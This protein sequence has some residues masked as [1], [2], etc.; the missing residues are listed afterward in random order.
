MNIVNKILYLGIDK[1]A[2]KEEV[3][4]IWL[5]NLLVLVPLP[6]FIFATAFSIMYNYPRV[7]FTNAI[8]ALVLVC[9]LL[10]NYSKKYT[11]AKFV[12]I[13]AFATVVLVYYK[14]MDNEASMFYYFFPLIL[15]M[16]LFYDVKQEKAVMILTATILVGIISV[17]LFLPAAYFQPWPLS[18]N[19]H[20]L[21]GTTNAI[22]C[23][24][25]IVI[26]TYNIF[27]QNFEK[28]QELIAAKVQAEAAA[29]A[30]S[31]FLRNMSHELRTPL[32]GIIGS[33]NILHSDIHTNTKEHVQVM[34]NLAMHMTNLVNDILDFDKIGAGKL[35]LHHADFSL[36][37]E[38]E[39]L[40]SL[41]H[42]EC[43]SKGIKYKTEIDPKLNDVI[44]LSDDLRLQQI[45]RN[46]IS[47]AIK[48]TAKGSVTLKI[49]EETKD[50]N[51]V[52]ITFNVIDEGIGIE[53]EKIDSVFESFNQGDSATTRKYGGSGLGLSISA[54]LLK[55]FGSKFLVRSKLGVGSNFSFTIKFPLS[56][57]TSFQEKLNTPKTTIGNLL[58]N[59]KVL[60]AEDNIINMKIAKL[61]LQKWGV[62]VEEANNGKVA[63]EKCKIQDFDLILLD[64][65][66]PE[67]DGKTA[68]KQINT[69]HKNIPAIAFTA[70]MYE[71][72]DQDLKTHGF[73]T[74]VTKPFK[75]EVLYNTMV[76]SLGLKQAI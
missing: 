30:K 21:I 6:L 55:M 68:V 49:N 39:K 23:T 8:F 31:V 12:F 32:N 13:T 73:D 66:M 28:E 9:I 76:A 67:M 48:F 1:N 52:T 51:F 5:V 18:N 40:H 14:L 70:A 58:R 2:T 42:F 20:K 65:E 24:L 41:Y 19:L 34:K 33:A 46:L 10:L 37:N 3:L 4:K 47:N 61:I 62:Q 75:P 63:F 71:D 15:C 56:K 64:L 11:L 45:L 43:L 22:G 38:I 57:S 53:S 59:K 16:L 60:I 50:N 44:L 36:K 69:L 7:V 29:N 26:Y 17:T 25:M 27:K 72:M 54:S 35:E 74:H